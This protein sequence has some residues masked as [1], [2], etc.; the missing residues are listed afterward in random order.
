MTITK[1]A[2]KGTLFLGAGRMADRGFQLLRNIIVA[3][4]VSPEDFGIAALFVMT[5]SLLE[6]I[7]NLAIDTLLIQSPQGDNPR[8]QQTSQLITTVRGLVITVI[9]FL[10]AAPVAGLFNIPATTWAFRL[11]AIVPLIRGLAHQDI[12]RL[13]RQL[14]YKS[15]LL[16]DVISQLV[17][18][19][20]AWPLAV[21]LGNYSA[22]LFLIIIQAVVRTIISHI[23]AERS[24]AWGWEPL[25]A[26]Q[27]M[28]FGWPLLINGIL[29]FVIMQGDRF[30]IGAADNLF[31]R[32]TYS[33]TLLGF[34]SAAYVLSQSILEAILSVLGPL[35]FPLL[36]SVQHDQSQFQK[37][38][39]FCIHIYA[40]ISSVM[41]IFFILMGSWFMVLVY[42]KQYIAAGPLLILFGIMQSIRILRTAP[43]TISLAK[44]DSRNTTISN[45]FR[46]LSF[47]L[48]FICAT[49]GMDIVWIAASGLIGELLAILPSLVML[50]YRFNIPMQHFIVPFISALAGIILAELLWYFCLFNASFLLA[51]FVAAVLSI[52]MAALFLWSFDEFYKEIKTILKPLLARAS[53]KIW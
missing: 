11:L 50:K 16:A 17:S 37:R 18:V 42:G 33:K 14:N 30:V 15:L 31:S 32:V 43:T 19:L 40:S 27:I 6:M 29:L 48:A 47:V 9:L 7:S 21:W 3:R 45:M 4:L 22:I 36:S 26:R 38:Y 25:H 49:R 52:C 5:I 53:F 35:M 23:V 1:T 20:C 10:F 2:I 44:G 51:F 24:Y 39:R 28:A 46:A 12:A 13:Q 34:Y 41:G 8:F